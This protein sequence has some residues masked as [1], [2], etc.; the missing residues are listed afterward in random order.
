MLAGMKRT[1]LHN[2]LIGQ[3]I[4]RTVIARHPETGDETRFESGKA[5]SLFAAGHKHAAG[6]ISKA[7][8]SGKLSN[9]FYWRKA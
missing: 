4:R 1:P 6:N 7:I 3:S 8:R 2:A 9:G 5:A